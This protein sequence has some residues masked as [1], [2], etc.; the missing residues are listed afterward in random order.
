MA[1]HSYH[2]YDMPTEVYKHIFQYLNSQEIFDFGTCSET[3]KTVVINEVQHPMSTALQQ[4]QTEKNILYNTTTVY[5][6]KKET[7]I[8]KNIKQCLKKN[9][10]CQKYKQQ[11]SFVMKDPK[12][13]FSCAK[14]GNK[15]MCAQCFHLIFELF[16]LDECKDCTTLG[17][18]CIKCATDLY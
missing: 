7:S 6:S 1:G 10:L 3:L 18:I 11:K 5:G 16:D 12:H 15:M 14:Y 2:I 8:F 4:I 17:K 9:C 13:C